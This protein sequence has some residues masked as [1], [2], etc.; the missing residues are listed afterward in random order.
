ML[1]AMKDSEAACATLGMS[2]TLTKLAVF[3]MSAAI[4]GLGG[5]LL[6][7]MTT[8][9]GAI[10]FASQASLPILLLA[11]IFGISTTSGPL[12]AGVAYT[13]G[14]AHL[15]SLVPQIPN[16]PFG[17]TGLSAIGVSRSPDGV[18]PQVVGIFK[19]TFGITGKAYEELEPDAAEAITQAP[20]APS[21][22]A[23]TA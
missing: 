1:L 2:L 13:L 23:N 18:V 11:V 22:V 5:A 4:A 8:E 3:A 10:T 9:A 14:G 7:A 15:Q 19:R 16:L 12:F 17:L 21:S 6:G 20:L